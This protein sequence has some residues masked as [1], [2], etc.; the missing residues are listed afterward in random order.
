MLPLWVDLV[1]TSATATNDVK[2]WRLPFVQSTVLAGTM[3]ELRDN[4]HAKGAF[5]MAPRYS[6]NLN[7]IAGVYG[8]VTDFS[9]RTQNVGRAYVYK[10][11][12]DTTP[13]VLAETSRGV[14][15][16]CT[17][18]DADQ[19]RFVVHR[20]QKHRGR[21]APLP[22]ERTPY[23]TSGVGLFMDAYYDMM[24]HND[25]GMLIQ[26]CAENGD[27]YESLVSGQDAE[28][29]PPGHMGWCHKTLTYD[30]MQA[31]YLTGS[32]RMPAPASMIEYVN[33]QVRMAPQ[34]HVVIRDRMT[35]LVPLRREKVTA[36][37]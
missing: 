18:V 35:P 37:A 27:H 19:L 21:A 13:V 1:T 25:L 17:K 30:Q 33:Q 26:L 15:L 34:L 6:V 10:R 2:V 14:M 8:V 9:W 28:R 4:A 36:E 7:R 32:F 12:Q 11:L 20:P 31:Q 16:D 22:D 29:T 23:A 24:M 3:R 5:E